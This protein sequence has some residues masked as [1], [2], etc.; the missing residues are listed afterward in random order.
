MSTCWSECYLILLDMSHI[1]WAWY[2]G[3]AWRSGDSNGHLWGLQDCEYDAKFL[4]AMCSKITWQKNPISAPLSFW[5]LC[6]PWLC[7]QSPCGPFI[8]WL[9]GPACAVACH[10][11]HPIKTC[12]TSTAKLKLF[13]HPDET[14][15]RVAALLWIKRLAT[16]PL[17]WSYFCMMCW[18]T[19]FLLHLHGGNQ[20]A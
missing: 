20:C 4:E 19:V 2:I 18:S 3:S 14:W 13:V 6:Q 8:Q 15:N 16:L 5:A 12:E 10:N 11:M 1:L 9:G 7:F 17:K